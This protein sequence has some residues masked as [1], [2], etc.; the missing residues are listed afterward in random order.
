MTA[1]SNDADIRE[2]QTQMINVKD[3]LVDLK[4]ESHDNFVVLSRKLDELTGIPIRVDTLERRVKNLEKSQWWLW[5]ERIVSMLFGG[6][7]LFLVQY[8]LTH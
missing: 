2:L 8:A 7:I 4:K 5:G 6:L 3:S 1:K